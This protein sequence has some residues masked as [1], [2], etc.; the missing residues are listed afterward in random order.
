MTNLAVAKIPL[1]TYQEAMKQ[2][3]EGITD[4]RVQVLDL[5]LGMWML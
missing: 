4:K 5:A 1:D 3:F 2:K